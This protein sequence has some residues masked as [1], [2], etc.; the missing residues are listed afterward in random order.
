[1]TDTFGARLRQLRRDR[2]F[3]HVV[4]A[5]RAGVSK[6]SLSEWENDHR[7]SRAADLAR[8]ARALHV[9]PHYLDTGEKEEASIEALRWISRVSLS[10]VAKLHNAMRAGEKQ[11]VLLAMMGE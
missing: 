8:L 5:A 9:S 6:S 1:M 3:S 10:D 7:P 11:E 2:G 4:L